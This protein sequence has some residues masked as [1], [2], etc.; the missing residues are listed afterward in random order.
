MPIGVLPDYPLWSWEASNGSATDA[1]VQ[2]AYNAIRN[3]G[4]TRDFSRLVWNDLVSL[5]SDAI[6]AAGLTWDDKCTTAEGAKISEDGDGTLTAAMFNSV[7]HNLDQ[8][9]PGFLWE[10]DKT[11]DPGYTGRLAFQSGEKVYGWY[12]E[13]LALVLN[14][15]LALLRGDE[16]YIHLL[17]C[18]TNIPAPRRGK[19]LSA[20]AAL[21]KGKHLAPVPVESTMESLPAAFARYDRIIDT[22]AQGLAS[23]K[24]IALAQF[25]R[26]IPVPVQS[27]VYH[28]GVER[29]LGHN[30]VAVAACGHLEAYIYRFFHAQYR[31]STVRQG[32]LVA[33][34]L[35]K[36]AGR[37]QAPV[38]YKGLANTLQAIFSA[39]QYLVST[40]H[41]GLATV[42]G[43]SKTGGVYLTAT[44][45]YGQASS[46][47]AI[48]SMGKYPTPV[49]RRGTAAALPAVAAGGN[50]VVQV[51]VLGC[52][53]AKSTEFAAGEYLV[54][55][56]HRG[57]AG[58]K[59]ITPASCASLIGYVSCSNLQWGYPLAIGGKSVVPQV[60]WALPAVKARCTPICGQVIQSP[61]SGIAQAV[62]IVRLSG[63]NLIQAPTRAV[64]S[65]EGEVEEKSWYD[66]V[67]TG[68][69]VYI[70]SVC[71]QRQEGSDVRLD[72]ES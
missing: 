21:P 14:I 62:N 26:L 53:D 66:P 41:R 48:F 10:W 72:A 40:A 2:A 42:H 12:L 1:Q 58:L 34:S 56:T 63:R 69:D 22:A 7:T 27:R 67:P 47:K 13:E 59:P 68:A 33:K 17:R 32:T 60:A 6:T 52:A 71:Y 18:G 31:I 16:N 11:Q 65:F 64:L 55:T 35:E 30:T 5:L 39:G 70:R 36:A 25:H 15:F 20:P 46:H 61:R 8:I 38:V 50:Y 54:A 19:L 23:D 24:A 45:Y 37:Y 44:A 43:A 9:N 3:Q 28:Y 4:Y 57:A 29:A 51:P 49:L